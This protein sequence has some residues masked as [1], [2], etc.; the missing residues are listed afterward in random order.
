MV[1]SYIQIQIYHI[2][3][4]FYHFQT[5]HTKFWLKIGTL[6][7]KGL[8]MFIILTITRWGQFCHVLPWDKIT[9]PSATLLCLSTPGKGCVMMMALGTVLKKA[10]PSSHVTRR[11]PGGTQVPPSL[12]PQ[13][14]L[15][16]CDVTGPC[17]RG[18]R[19]WNKVHSRQ[20]KLLHTC[21]WI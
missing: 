9:D 16:T 12:A 1:P 2:L 7:I 8:F 4:N 14:Y 20:Y 6:R 13:P 10:G 15:S 17:C 21:Q 19:R 18:D 11:I 5:R 3:E